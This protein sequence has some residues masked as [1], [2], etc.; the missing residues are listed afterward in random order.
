MLGL[1]CFK[2]GKSLLNLNAKLGAVEHDLKYNLFVEDSASAA[3]ANDLLSMESV[4]L[5][6]R[7]YL[8]ASI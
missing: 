1:S 6:N 5:W 4:S 3:Y 2:R 8:S 7:D